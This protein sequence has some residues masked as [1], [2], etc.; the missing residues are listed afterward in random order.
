ML[1]SI[2]IVIII[3]ILLSFIIYKL[4]AGHGNYYLINENENL[5]NIYKYD[6]HNKLENTFYFM[7]NSKDVII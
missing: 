4:K 3:I 7:D 2:I 5:T 1:I 6:E